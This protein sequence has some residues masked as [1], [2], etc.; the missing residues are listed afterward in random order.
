[1]HDFTNIEKDIDIKNPEQISKEIAI[2]NSKSYPFIVNN[3]MKYIIIKK[4]SSPNASLIELINDYCIKKQV[5]VELVGD[6]I[7]SDVYFTSFIESDCKFNNIIGS[8]H[9]SSDLW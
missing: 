8:E 4:E 3:V 6:A 2:E 5:P 7:A 1:M 9:K